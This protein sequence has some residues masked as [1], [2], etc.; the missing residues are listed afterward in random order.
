M[1]VGQ[2]LH[3][4]SQSNVSHSERRADLFRPSGLEDLVAAWDSE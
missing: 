3:P 1:D 2:K 4:H